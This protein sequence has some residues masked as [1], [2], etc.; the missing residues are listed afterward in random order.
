M[1][2]KI[3]NFFSCFC[4]FLLYSCNS[5]SS[6]SQIKINNQL[7]NYNY[8]QGLGVS[9]IFQSGLGDGQSVWEKIINQ[10]PVH[11]TYFTYDRPGYGKSDKAKTERSPC[12]IAIEQHDLLVQAGVK[13][14]Y[15]LVG[16]SIGGLYEYVFALMYPQDVAGLILLDPTHP[17]HWETMQAQAPVSAA[18]VNT[19]R[20]TVFT[21]VERNEFDMQATCLN[22]LPAIFDKNIAGHTRIFAS[23]RV[24]AGEQGA[25]QDM[26]SE[27]RKDWL[28]LTGINAI[29]SV[30]DSGHY[31]QKDRPD[32]VAQ[33]IMSFSVK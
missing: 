5:L 29:E 20:H 22:N 23:T 3:R 9:V 7:V 4:F 17:K 27:L 2:W 8:H 28:T 32:V 14:P 25:Y 31:I 1:L 24:G 16:H 19:L 11:Q 30:P 10:L 33:A 18:L 12:D 6:S 21:S 26:L 15:L 13:P